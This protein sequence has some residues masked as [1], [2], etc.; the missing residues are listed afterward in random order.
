MARMTGGEAI[1]KALAREG[2]KV[3]FG[4]P[5][6]RFLELAGVQIGD[7]SYVRRFARRAKTLH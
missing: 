3:A 1:V 5:G 6:V 2:V 4:L 7:P